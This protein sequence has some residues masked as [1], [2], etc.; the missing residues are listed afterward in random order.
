VSADF[1]FDTQ[2]DCAFPITVRAA[3]L[4]GNILKYAGDLEDIRSAYAFYL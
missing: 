2:F 3:R 4:A 1:E